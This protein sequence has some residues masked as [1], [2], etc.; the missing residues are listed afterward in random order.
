ML[1][2]EAIL[3][4]MSKIEA[5]SKDQTNTQS[6][7]KFRGIDDIYNAVYR[8][9]VESE[10]FCVPRVLDRQEEIYA[11]KNGSRMIRVVLK[12]EYDFV[13][14]DGSTLTVGPI[15]SEGND[16]SDKATNKA[17]A[18]GHKYAIIQLFCI[19][20][21]DQSDAD[22]ETP[23]LPELQKPKVKPEDTLIFWGPKKG[24]K[25]KDLTKDEL[26]HIM[27]QIE[28]RASSSVLSNQVKYFYS[29]AK[30]FLGLE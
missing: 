27:K 22:F 9:F 5:I 14:L 28:D 4:A 24:T 2:H 18:V 11:S 13:A 25:I 12:T 7:Y 3:K 20:T 19:P 26:D 23:K 15:F 17:L 21:N 1:I 29:Q 6:N 16:V 10:I 30:L 8:P